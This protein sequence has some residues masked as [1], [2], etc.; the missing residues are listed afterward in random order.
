[1]V[2]AE[3]IREGRRLSKLLDEALAYLAQQ[4]HLASES[5]RD[6][7]K[8]QGEMILRAPAGTVLEKDA[9]LKAECAD[10]RFTRDLADGMRQAALEAVRSRRTQVS[11]LQ[12]FLA[13]E[14][15][16]MALTRTGP[17]MGA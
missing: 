1:M 14:R 15:E 12:S 3:L 7:R 11:L 8:M 6:Y 9:W 5:E 4:V 2:D 10:A 17:E 16:E 13:G